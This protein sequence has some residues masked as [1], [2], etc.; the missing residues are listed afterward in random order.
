MSRIIIE[1]WPNGEEK[2]S[3]GYDRPLGYFFVDV[4]D[5]DG[6]YVTG[7][8]LLGA[9][10]C[11]G[12]TDAARTAM[13]YGDVSEDECRRIEALLTEHE[14]LEYPAS[15]VVVDLTEETNGTA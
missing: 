4:Y 14:K 1:R 8:G 10:P 9:R 5:A 7:I 11:A 3:A 2:L 15:N 13:S 6:E 12:P